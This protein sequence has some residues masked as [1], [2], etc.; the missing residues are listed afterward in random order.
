[1]ILENLTTK[2]QLQEK[3]LAVTKKAVPLRHFLRIQ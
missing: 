2:Q 3:N 1:M